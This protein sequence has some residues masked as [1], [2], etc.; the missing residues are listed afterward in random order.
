M[1]WA[2]EGQGTTPRQCVRPKKSDFFLMQMPDDNTKALDYKKSIL[3]HG[4]VTS[5][6]FSNGLWKLLAIRSISASAPP[7]FI[8][9]GLWHSQRVLLMQH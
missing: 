7:T 6:S 5:F 8:G 1:K 3:F 4:T 2:A 9:K